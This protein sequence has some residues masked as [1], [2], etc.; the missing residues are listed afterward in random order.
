MVERELA[1]ELVDL[2]RENSRPNDVHQLVET[3][4]NQC[5]SLAHAGKSARPVE[6]DL[7]GFAQ[8]GFCGFDVVHSDFSLVVLF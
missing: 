7:S 8:G 6:L 5:A 3:F 4:R 2:R 1:N